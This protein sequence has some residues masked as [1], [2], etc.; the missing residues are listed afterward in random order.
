MFCSA[1]RWPIKRSVVK[2]KTKLTKNTTLTFYYINLFF[3]H[4]FQTQ[5]GSNCS[6]K[7][8]SPSNTHTPRLMHFKVFSLS[9]GITIH[10]I[11]Q[12]VCAYVCIFVKRCMRSRTYVWQVALAKCG[13]AVL[14]WS[15]TCQFKNLLKKKLWGHS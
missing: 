11:C 7:L 2:W 6:V 8:F 9:L 13:L 1:Q 5:I 3:S 4:S 12:K 15:K 10:Q 14:Y